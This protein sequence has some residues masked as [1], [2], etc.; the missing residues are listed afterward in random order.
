MSYPPA[1]LCET[2]KDLPDWIKLGCGN[3]EYIC[4][5]KGATFPGDNCPDTLP[6]LSKHNN[7][8]ANALRDTPGLYDKYKNVKT[9]GGVSLAKCIKTGIDNPGHPHI[10]TCGLVA[11]DEDCFHIFKDLFD[12]V[13]GKR[14]GDYAP[15]AKH[16]TDMDISKLSTTQIDPD[17]KYVLTTRCR[18]GRS[19]KGLPLPPA[20][21][22]EQR[23]ETERVI[24][25][26]LNKLQGEL[27]GK[28]YPLNGSQSMDGA[29]DGE[30]EERLRKNGNLFQEPDSTLL[31][32]SG[33]GRHWPDARG[34][35]HNDAENFF[36]WV[37]EEDQ[38]RIVSMEK[39][40]NIKAIF[41]RFCDA[42]KAVQ[43]SLEDDG[44][45]IMHTDHLGYVLTCPSNLGT[46][47]RAGCMVKVPKF[48]SRPDFK[49]ILK[50]MRL[51][52][53][54]TSGVDSAST[55]GTWD[56]SNS[57]RL[58]MSEVQLC[59]LFIEGLAQVIRWEKK[60]EAGESIDEEV[61]SAKP[62]GI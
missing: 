4:P 44:Y 36:V 62:L 51:Q 14:N 11:G 23:R 8:C 32:S 25:N 45:G 37:N 19:V 53:R 27:K 39:G 5:E 1:G 3:D 59:N 31:L 34:I 38:M 50:K 46:G 2:L 60:L 56:I 54:G 17:G 40:D 7:L 42:T 43:A 24:V 35:F 21:S 58:G 10:M 6:D 28:Y 61:A 55:G 29:M 22:F 12:I 41:Q 57:D 13:I 15:D 30:K 48:S 26:G 52:A 33:C 16:P 20:C 49:D 9:P 18:T 47:L